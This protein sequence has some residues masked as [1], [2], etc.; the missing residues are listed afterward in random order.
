MF[1]LIDLLEYR[2]SGRRNAAV[3]AMVE[4]ESGT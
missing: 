1:S 4:Q 3:E 2:Q